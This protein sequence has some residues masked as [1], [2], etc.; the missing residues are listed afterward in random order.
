MTTAFSTLPGFDVDLRILEN[1]GIVHDAV[2]DA[3]ILLTR[4]STRV[5]AALLEG[6]RVRFAA[7]ATIGDDH[8]DKAYLAAHNIAFANAAGSS[9]GSV[10]EY[11]AAALLHLH[12]GNTMPIP[13][14]TLGIIGAGRIGARVAEMAEGLGM[15]VLLNDPPRAR[16]EG[17]APFTELDALL[18]EAD[19]ISLHT[20]LTRDGSDPTFHLLDTVALA[21]FSGRGIINAARGGVVDNG[22]LAEWLD[23]DRN[24]FTVM[25]C[26]EHEPAIDPRLLAHDGVVLAT[27]HI[28]GHSLDGKAANT[29][30]VYD[31]L[32]RYLGIEPAWHMTDLLPAIETEPL[33]IKADGNLEALH[34]AALH[35]Y[36]I[37]ADSRAL[38]ECIGMDESATAAA[39]TALRR[40]YPVRRR[41]GLLPIRFE[42]VNPELV[43]MAAALG[44]KVI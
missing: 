11:M 12:A 35:L 1:R 36:D 40:N 41:W 19:V 30:Y 14:T 29:Q 43:Q 22:A 26:W 39:F 5:D 37:T 4:S 8:Y 6:A 44:M 20:P 13:G 28:A 27:P 18:S 10:L 2:K 21:R 32:C 24:R 9:T 31:A 42:P 17:S 38:K 7:T 3:D 34:H 23:T 25:D 16:R 33:C 15:R